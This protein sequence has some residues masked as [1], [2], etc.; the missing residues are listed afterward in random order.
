MQRDELLSMERQCR[1]R[2]AALDVGLDLQR[3]SDVQT[4]CACLARHRHRPLHLEAYRLPA[5]LGG[6]W[7]AGKSR[8]YI[9]YPSDAPLP[10]QEHGILHEVSHVICGH[11][12]LHA[13]ME[14]VREQ[15]F[16]HV[17][18]DLVDRAL[19]RSLYATPQ[20]C[21]A[22]FLASLLAARFEYNRV[23]GGKCPAVPVQDVAGRLA[24]FSAG[25]HIW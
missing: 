1:H 22:E 24:V 4:F 15:L 16:P 13:E 6:L 18:K 25:L 23:R 7:L 21:E 2:L 17:P 20:E 5:A 10:Q 11:D 9:F 8:D 14:L 19:G 12:P 3:I